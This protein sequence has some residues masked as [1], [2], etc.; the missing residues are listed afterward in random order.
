MIVDK[1][2][3][4]HRRRL[5]ARQQPTPLPV[6]VRDGLTNPPVVR[7]SSWELMLPPPL[8]N[9]LWGLLFQKTFPFIS[10][11]R[12]IVKF[13]P[14]NED[15]G[16]AVLMRSDVIAQAGGRSAELQMCS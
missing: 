1:L 10:N 3:R 9:R 5:S 2:E 15:D 8:L 4:I 13:P 16:D 7:I 12:E 6:S 14:L 11:R